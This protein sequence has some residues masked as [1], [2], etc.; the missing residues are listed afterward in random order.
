MEF[1]PIEMRCDYMKSEYAITDRQNPVFTWGAV[2][3]EK[4]A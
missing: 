2:N 1:Y 4:G 3:Q